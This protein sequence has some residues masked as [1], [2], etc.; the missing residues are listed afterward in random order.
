M[1][2]TKKPPE[3]RRQQL[4]DIG[5][6]LFLHNGVAGVS[7][8]DIV[9]EAG[10]ATGL[11]YYYFKSKEVFL[12]EAVE[13]YVMGQIQQYQALL[14]CE[15]LTLLGRLQRV[16]DEFIT[17]MDQTAQ[18]IR[19]NDVTAPQHRIIVE[20]MLQKLSPELEVFIR[21]GCDE[22]IFY[23]LHPAVTA[24]FLLHGLSGVFHMGRNEDS[25]Q[26]RQAEIER[27]TSAALGISEE[28]SR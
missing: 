15:E 22:G 2:R 6:E 19:E 17:S 14:Q 16:V 23:V 26:T 24:Q 7:V 1:S 21:R 27:L 4:L 5:I 13:S 12:D 18:V 10:V 28:R 8:Q 9:R 3:E 11:F 25:H 20:A